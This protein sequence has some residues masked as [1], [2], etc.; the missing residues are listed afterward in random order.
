MEGRASQHSLTQLISSLPLKRFFPAVTGCIF[1]LFMVVLALGARQYLLYQQCSQAVEAS[2]RLLFNYTA[3]QKYI[4]ESLVSDTQM[5]L[6]RLRDELNTLNTSTN[7]LR[8]SILIKDALK[9]SLVSRNELVT[10]LTDLQK[11][12]DQKTRPLQ[13]QLALI[14]KL[15]TVSQRLQDFR[16][17]LSDHTQAILQG[18]HSFIIGILALLFVIS[19]SL[20]FTI[21]RS[22]GRPLTRLCSLFQQARYGPDQSPTSAKAISMDRLVVQIRG[23]LA[24]HDRAIDLFATLQ[25]VLELADHCAGP[26]QYQQE[27]CNI[28]TANPDFCYCWLAEADGQGQLRP[29]YGS[30]GSRG[31]ELAPLR[32]LLQ[33]DQQREAI[34]APA[35][36]CL[37]SKSMVQ[38]DF[39]LSLLPAELECIPGNQPSSG[40][41]LAIPLRLGGLVQ[42]IV[43]LYSPLEQGFSPQYLDTLGVALNQAQRQLPQPGNSPANHSPAPGTSERLD[44]EHYLYS[45][46]GALSSEAAS[47]ITNLVNGTIN[48]TQQLIDLSDN[49][50]GQAEVD[51][52]LGN[53][54][55]EEQRIASLARSMVVLSKQTE[56]PQLQAIQADAFFQGLRSLLEKPLQAQAISLQLSHRDNPTLPMPPGIL[57]LVCL[58]LVQLARLCCTAQT[59]T[60]QKCISLCC[61]SNPE[62]PC[63]D[64][65]HTN[66]ADQWSP[67]RP[68]PSPAWPSLE[69]CTLLMQQH[70]GDLIHEQ[71]PHGPARLT[72][73]LPLP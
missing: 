26:E 7:S 24:E 44:T 17:S 35:L 22:L 60:T 36:Q 64:I 38:Q 46:A 42:K 14:K 27:L 53:L 56:P 67:A 70:G 52:V 32:R 39:D 13:S 33:R 41:C 16:L 59:T 49:R 50:D 8:K 3:L 31:D 15:N 55:R 11:L 23:L 40:S 25:A 10:L 62:I 2:D 21:N 68:E 12:E 69:Q 51:K 29:C 6:S 30:C 73:R 34:C 66:S 47:T 4:S 45:I 72:L 37:A 63:I 28:L 58:T 48:Y 19:C 18:L 43:L 71:P 54:L 5:N 9:S 20:L 65:L 57:R 61:L 1:I